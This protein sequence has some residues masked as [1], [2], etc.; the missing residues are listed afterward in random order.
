MINSLQLQTL[1][2]EVHLPIEMSN[3]VPVLENGHFVK[4]TTG[5]STKVEEHTLNVETE[6]DPLSKQLKSVKLRDAFYQT[7]YPWGDCPMDIGS[8]NLK[9][10][11]EAGLIQ[12]YDRQTG[13]LESMSPIV[14]PTI[15]AGTRDVY[16]RV[17]DEK[18]YIGRRVKEI[19]FSE[20][21]QEDHVRKTEESLAKVRSW[22]NS[23]P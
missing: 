17:N 7:T 20:V 8:G 6:Y 19:P 2:L 14:K 10:G 9:N 1:D 13:K 23:S 15:Y 12:V 22:Y 18:C 4:N 21:L 3:G 5:V 11:L 16:N